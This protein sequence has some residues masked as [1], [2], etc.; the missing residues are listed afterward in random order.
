MRALKFAL[1]FLLVAALVRASVLI[2]PFVF[3]TASGAPS[4]RYYRIYCAATGGAFGINIREIEI[5]TATT[6]PAD[7][8]L[9]NANDL[10]SGKTFTASSSPSGFN[11]PANAFDDTESTS[12]SCGSGSDAWVKV[13]C[14]TA[15][16][17][18]SANVRTEA[19]YVTAPLLLQGSTD[20]SSWTTLGTISSPASNTTSGSLGNVTAAQF[21]S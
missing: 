20:D 1:W 21:P 19:I 8:L 15:V 7:I 3:A 14:A 5:F 16:A 12:W 17:A 18:R 11:G 4:Y 10:T 9:D 13:D 2:N 6:S